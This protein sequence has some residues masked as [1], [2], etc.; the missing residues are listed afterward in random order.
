MRAICVI[1]RWVSVEC[2]TIKSK[3]KAA[4]AYPS[5]VREK[6]TRSIELDAKVYYIQI[7][8]ISSIEHLSFNVFKLG[9][10]SE[11]MYQPISAVHEEVKVVVADS[12]YT[13]NENWK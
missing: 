8:G 6:A 10:P 11:G 2:C 13:T 9:C 1:L 4:A 12:I 7:G 3:D 5:I